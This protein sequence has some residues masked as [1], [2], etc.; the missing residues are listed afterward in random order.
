[1]GFSEIKK[2]SQEYKELA[3]DI[4]DI[5]KNQKQ[6]FN[7]FME[8]L[9]R[10]A[11]DIFIEIAK[12]SDLDLKPVSLIKEA[13]ES[14]KEVLLET[15]I[16]RIPEYGDIK[17]LDTQTQGTVIFVDI[18]KST[19]YFK[20][21]KN[22]TGFVIFNAYILLVKTITRLTGGEFLEHTGDGA[23]IFYEDKNLI[24]EYKNYKRF[25][26]KNPIWLYF[27]VSEYIKDYAKEKG[28]LNFK[29]N[30]LKIENGVI[31]KTEPALVHIGA[32]YG[33]VLGVKLGNIKKLFSKT[34]WNAAKRCKEAD[35]EVVYEV[36]YRGGSY[37]KTYKYDTYK[38]LPIKLSDY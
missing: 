26:Q 35:R 7:I 14:A 30:V 25:N 20:E 24:E 37:Y 4:E 38:K 11:L 17:I 13:M 12:I 3:K 27:I 18:T 36:K 31:L 9:S 21:E 6:F 2:L 10:K 32:D 19:D 23:L 15:T 16:P 1:M 34:V 29:S 33:E 22:Y 5:M 8:L 28:L